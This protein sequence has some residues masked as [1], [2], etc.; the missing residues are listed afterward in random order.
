[1]KEAQNGWA[2]RFLIHQHRVYCSETLWRKIPAKDLDP[3]AAYRL[4]V[5]KK[6]WV[7]KSQEGHC[8]G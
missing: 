4:R 2:E 3:T 6:R 5:D 7:E 1:M 8:M